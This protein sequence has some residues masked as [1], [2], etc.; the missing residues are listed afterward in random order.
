MSLNQ[1]VFLSLP[2]SDVICLL[3]FQ[4]FLER[5][6]GLKS[7]VAPSLWLWE[8]GFLLA[9]TWMV[10]MVTYN[11]LVQS[12]NIHSPIIKLDSSQSVLGTMSISS[13]GQPI[14]FAVT[15]E[16]SK[17][18]EVHIQPIFHL[19]QV[20]ARGFKQDEASFTI[21]WKIYTSTSLRD[22]VF[23]ST[24]FHRRLGLGACKLFQFSKAHWFSYSE[25]ISLSPFF[26][27]GGEVLFSKCFRCYIYSSLETQTSDLLVVVVAVCFFTPLI[28]VLPLNILE[29]LWSSKW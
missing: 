11:P 29:P 25:F 17:S 27:G 16:S 19:R 8:V 6:R 20:Q 3:S 9:G 7:E 26:F 22:A 21:F 13:S 2:L 18:N 23:Q 5:F 14:S 28:Y 1:S 15:Q 4:G 12:Y 24:T 10:S